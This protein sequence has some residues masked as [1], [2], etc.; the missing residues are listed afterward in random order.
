IVMDGQAMNITLT[1]Y[2]DKLEVGIIACRRTLP[3][4]QSLLSLLED[5]IQNFEHLTAHIPDPA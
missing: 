2:M 3:R 1:S 4:I 5:E